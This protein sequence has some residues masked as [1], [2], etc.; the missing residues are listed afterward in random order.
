MRAFFCLLVSVLLN[1]YIF[2]QTELD[3][4]VLKKINEHRVSNGLDELQFLSVGF[5]AAEHHSNYLA[6]IKDVRHDEDNY[7]TSSPT[8]R[9]GYY[10]SGYTGWVGEN[11]ADTEDRNKSIDYQATDIFNLW[12]NSPKHNANMLNKNFKYGAVSCVKYSGVFSDGEEYKRIV[13]TF[14]AWN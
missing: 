10:G 8:R 9:L 11:C 12:L 5:D 14:I 3:M 13:A 4:L 7:K 6:E 1:N 2:S